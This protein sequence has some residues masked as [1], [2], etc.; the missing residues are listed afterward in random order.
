MPYGFGEAPWEVPFLFLRLALINS[1]TTVVLETTEHVITLSIS[2][3]AQY[4]EGKISRRGIKIA[5]GISAAKKTKS[6]KAFISLTKGSRL[7][8]RLTSKFF[9]HH[10]NG[11]GRGGGTEPAARHGCHHGGTSPRSGVS[12]H[13]ERGMRSDCAMISVKVLRSVLNHGK[14]DLKTYPPIFWA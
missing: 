14:W 10:G 13:G 8:D 3:C 5:N 12:R 11:G 9:P 2:P 1:I 7:Q 4:Q 6:K